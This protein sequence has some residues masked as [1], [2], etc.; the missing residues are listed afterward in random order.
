M[1]KLQTFAVAAMIAVLAIACNQ[2]KAEES[3]MKLTKAPYDT[4]FAE[5]KM[6]AANGDKPIVI[7]FYTDWCTWCKKLDTEV[8]TDPRTIDFFTNKMVLFK[9]NAEVDTA[10][11]HQ[12]H[13]SGYP[14]LVMTDSKGNE[15]DRIIGYEPTEPFLQD[16]ENFQKGI[17][18]L[19]DLLQRADTSTDR[20]LYFQIADKYKYRGGD[21]DAITWYNKVIAAGQP[22]DSMSGE[23][24]FAIAD[25]YLRSQKYDQALD[26]YGE[27]SK[28][29][30]GSNFAELA[31][32]YTGIAYTK[33]GD[34]AKAISAYEKFVKVH[35]NS[36]DTSYARTQIS[37]L[38]GTEAQSN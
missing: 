28:N 27:I 23:S 11:S 32:I 16:L 2:K 31:D 20:D 19:T 10:L 38:K 4:T 25:M 26:G 14:T 22:T 12:F 5:A 18:T 7:D 9:T 21:D 34:T 1:R 35:P 37:K 6:A 29:F 13:I 3:T 17:G 30:K 33:K 36:E 15:I 8:Y 24:K